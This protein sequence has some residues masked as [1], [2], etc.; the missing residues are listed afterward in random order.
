MAINKKLEK[1]LKDNKIKYQILEHRKV[2]TAWDAAETQHLKESEVAKA[3]L[4]KGKKGL[5]LA[6][7]GAVP[8]HCNFCSGNSYVETRKR[9]W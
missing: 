9:N 7:L 4:L 3:V 8:R 1:L 2:Y 6:V 5:F